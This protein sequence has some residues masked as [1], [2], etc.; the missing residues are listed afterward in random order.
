MS[1]VGILYP[2][3]AISNL[4]IARQNGDGTRIWPQITIQIWGNNVRNE[5]IRSLWMLWHQRTG[6]VSLCPQPVWKEMK[7]ERCSCC[8]EIETTLYITT[9]G[10]QPAVRV[11]TPHPR[12]CL[13]FILTLTLLWV[14]LLLYCYISYLCFV[15]LAPLEICTYSTCLCLRMITF[16]TFHLSVCSYLLLQVCFQ[17]PLISR[18]P[19]F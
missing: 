11:T 12:L 5:H 4:E 14:L 17:R 3:F 6:V 1:D 16:T 9:S 8:W 2:P 7:K 19:C 13:S 15:C 10:D 18:L